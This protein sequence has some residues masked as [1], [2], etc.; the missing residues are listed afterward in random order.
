[1]ATRRSPPL[2]TITPYRG[3]AIA[4]RTIARDSKGSTI[5][6]KRA[7]ARARDDRGSAE[8]RD[9]VHS[10]ATKAESL[11]VTV[12]IGEECH[13]LMFGTMQRTDW[14]GHGLKITH[15]VSDFAGSTV[16][17]GQGT[18]DVVRLHFGLRGDYRVRYPQL[19]RSYDLVGGHHNIF[20]AKN[21]ELE[22]VNKTPSIETFGV[23]FQ[24]AQFRVLRRWQ[25]RRAVEILR[26]H[27]GR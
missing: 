21:F 27:R 24:V 20:Y 5:R 10:R 4:S 25:Q 7:A 2:E 19:D 13:E 9:L 26:A 23:Q 6:A 3:I 15:T 17:R 16:H 11:F 1:L 12:V 8:T 18:D 22:F 14:V